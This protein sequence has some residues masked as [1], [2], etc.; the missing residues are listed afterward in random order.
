[1]ASK[2]PLETRGSRSWVGIALGVFAAC[3]V[4]GSL[5]VVGGLG[6]VAYLWPSESDRIEADC[7]AAV[8]NAPDLS[9]GAPEPTEMLA[10]ECLIYFRDFRVDLREALACRGAATTS[11]Q[12]AACPADE[13]L[14]ESPGDA[15]LSAALAAARAKLE[16]ET[17]PGPELAGGAQLGEESLG[18]EAASKALDGS[19]DTASTDTETGSQESAESPRSGPAAS[20]EASGERSVESMDGSSGK[21]KARSRERAAAAPAPTPAPAPA[22]TSDSAPSSAPSAESEQNGEALDVVV[23]EPPPGR[24]SSRSSAREA[25]SSSPPEPASGSAFDTTGLTRGTIPGGAIKNLI[26]RS[27]YDFRPCYERERSKNPD[28]EGRVV[29]RVLVGS[30][31]AVTATELYSSTLDNQRME[32][33]LLQRMTKVR[34][35]SPTDGDFALLKIPLTFRNDD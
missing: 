27:M 20:A 15:G 5:V 10:E 18:D 28:L 30:Y 8:F 22:P 11:E 4:L 12:W 3:I 2:Q 1:M 6:L 9:P 34:F 16:E 23:A 7:R 35:P 17:G 13:G 26:R 31:G 19:L 33:C 32:Q 24:R 25:S 21:A 29:L 14:L